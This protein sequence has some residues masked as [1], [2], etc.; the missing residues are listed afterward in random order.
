MKPIYGADGEELVCDRC[1]LPFTDVTCINPH[2]DEEEI[3]CERCF[4]KL[5]NEYEKKKCQK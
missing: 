4:V 1:F 2:L 5:A 3:L